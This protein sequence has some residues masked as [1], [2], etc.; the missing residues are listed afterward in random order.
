[1][2]CGLNNEKLIQKKIKASM[3]YSNKELETE[4]SCGEAVV[5]HIKD[6]Y[7]FSFYFITF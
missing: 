2:T 1:M 3:E 4:S 5:N 6:M 7:L